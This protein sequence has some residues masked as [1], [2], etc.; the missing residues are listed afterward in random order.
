MALTNWKEADSA[1]AK[2][3]WT[4]YCRQHDLSSR[5]GQTAGIDPYSGRLWF[6]ESIRDIVSQRD[7]EGFNSPLFFE[8]IGSEA[9]FHN[10]TRSRSSRT[11]TA[12]YK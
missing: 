2:E 6:G 12:D 3:I 1:K 4:E 5:T 11:T 9:Y 10:L 7:A 8:R